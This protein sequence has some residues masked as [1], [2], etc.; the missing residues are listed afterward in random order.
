MTRDGFGERGMVSVLGI[1]ILCVLTFFG[2]AIY[3][4]SELHMASAR[5]FCA[6]EALRNAAEGGVR[7]AFAR[8]NEDASMAARAEAATASE[9]MLVSFPWHEA[10][11]SAYARKK[12]GRVILLGVGKQ[13]DERARAAAVLARSGTSY[14]IDHW[15]H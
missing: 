6:R 14:V 12:E 13:G 11:V 4:V 3:A 1:G 9:V 15:E 7:V 10:S 5:R 8:M 2:A